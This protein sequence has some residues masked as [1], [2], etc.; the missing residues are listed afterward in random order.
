MIGLGRAG[1]LRAHNDVS[2]VALRR[3]VVGMEM[4]CV[5]GKQDDQVESRRSV[6]SLSRPH[7]PSPSPARQPLRQAHH[8][9]SSQRKGG[10]IELVIEIETKGVAGEARVLRKASCSED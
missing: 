2:A 5:V 1:G 10:T 8:A 4:D 3:L 6:R 7:A 9:L